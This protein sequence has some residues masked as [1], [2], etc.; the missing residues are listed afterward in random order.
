MR[1]FKKIK[2]L[3]RILAIKFYDSTEYNVIPKDLFD[4]ISL[5]CKNKEELR[6]LQQEI[7]ELKSL[8]PYERKFLTAEAVIE[9]MLIIG[10]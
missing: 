5:N 7:K 6:L 1:I 3:I 2:Y 8:Y 4:R 9:R 10:R